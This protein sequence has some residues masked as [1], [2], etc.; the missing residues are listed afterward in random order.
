MVAVALRFGVQAPEVDLGAP[1][2]QPPPLPRCSSSLI[3]A[4]FLSFFASFQKEQTR[5]DIQVFVPLNALF[6]SKACNSV[7]LTNCHSI[8]FSVTVRCVVASVSTYTAITI[9]T[10]FLSPPLVSTTASICWSYS[11]FFDLMHVQ[12]AAI[13]TTFLCTLAPSFP[14][15]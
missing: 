15:A 1:V 3:L 6:F 5:H 2:R 12:Y 13:K 10:F 9:R 14:Q 11:T 7:C 4:T 8:G